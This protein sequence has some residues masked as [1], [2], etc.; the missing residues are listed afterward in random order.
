MKMTSAEAAKLV[1]ELNETHEALKTKEKKSCTFVCSL[2]EDLESVRPAYLFEETQKE[3]DRLEKRIR[4]VK[5]AINVF[6]MTTEVPGFDMTVDQLLVYIPQLSERKRRMAE[7]AERLPKERYDSS[8]F[9]STIIDY[10]YTNYSPAAAEA[11]L[12]WTTRELA[13][14][15]TALDTLNNSVTFEVEA[16][17][18]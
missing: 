7:M 16:G 6:N 17:E 18:E 2:N 10:R 13:R 3:L 12:L 11:A 8:S 14:A 15:Q 1:R 4:S 9:A 5:H